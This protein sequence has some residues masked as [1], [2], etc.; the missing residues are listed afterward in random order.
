MSWEAMGHFSLPAVL[1]MG[2][3]GSG[4]GRGCASSSRV[5]Y[6]PLE[7]AHSGFFLPGIISAPKAWC[8]APCP[9]NGSGS[10]SVPLLASL[11][12]PGVQDAFQVRGKY[13]IGKFA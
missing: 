6:Q 5:G 9:E 13:F 4:A 1:P 8:P 3:P 10:G 7:G 2:E 12:T 11:L